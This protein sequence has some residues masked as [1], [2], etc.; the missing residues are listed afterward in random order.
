MNT[1][2]EQK[3]KRLAD[4]LDD[5]RQ[6][7]NLTKRALARKLGLNTT[8]I[9]SYLDCLTFPT[10]EN[11]ERIA[12]ALDMTPPELE[13]YLDDISLKPLRQLEQ[14]KQ[15]IRALDRRDFIEIAQVVCDRLLA[16]K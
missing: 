10:L 8:S 6:R 13:A 15:D 12:R 11:R 3:R 14:I 4:L 7:N 16:E 1:E 2:P 5:Y 9:L